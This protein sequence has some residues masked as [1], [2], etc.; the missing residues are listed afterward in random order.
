[1]NF[2]T[3]NRRFGILTISSVFLLLIAG[4]V[5][6]STGSGM[7]CPDWPKC[8]DG[9][10]PPTNINQLPTNYRDVYV[11]K[12]VKKTIK[13]AKLMHK[14]GFEKEADQL[15]ND[16]VLYLPEDF[17]TKKAWTEYINRI[18]GVLSGLFSLGFFI[19]L[20]KTRFYSHKTK[21][22][23]GIGGFVLMLFNGWLGSIV[24]ATN[25]FP[26]IVTIHYL[27]AYAALTLL[28]ISVLEARGN[29]STQILL[30]YKWFY[31][32][33]I[34]FSLVQISYGTQLRQLSDFS[35]KNGSLYTNGQVNL[36]TL[37]SVFIWHRIFAI[38]LILFSI[39]PIIQ[40]RKLKDKKWR[41]IA[42]AI[43]VTFI[44]QYISGIL[45]LR[46]NFPF[47]PQVSHIFFA[48]VV[49]GLS[50]YICISNFSSQNN[51]SNLG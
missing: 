4:G 8:F 32:F 10:T 43:P 41:N 50:L 5:V 42:L 25:L 23:T 47:V 2:K 9:Y 14:L 26:I 44:I 46:Y 20:F 48:G 33:L 38:A 35:L 6:R 16:P 27:L 45:N 18:I 3:L 51:A 49:F 11:E 37:G 7:G 39:F 24:V 28:M 15:L 13:F 19:T 31:L 34:L 17:N 29:E 40:L 30:K 21:F 36:Q 22:W 12:R 1:M